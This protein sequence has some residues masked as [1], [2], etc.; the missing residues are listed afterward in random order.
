GGVKVE[1]NHPV[2]GL[3]GGVAEGPRML[4]TFEKGTFDPVRVRWLGNLNNNK[5]GPFATTTPHP[6][7]GTLTFSPA[8]KDIA[9]PSFLYKDPL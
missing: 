8:S 9:V 3:R 7:K 6:R 1:G 2:I 5:G 4:V